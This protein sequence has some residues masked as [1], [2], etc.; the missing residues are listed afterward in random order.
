VILSGHVPRRHLPT[1]EAEIEQ[2]IAIIR[3]LFPA[4]RPEGSVGPATARSRGF[5][6]IVDSAVA[7]TGAQVDI[8]QARAGINR[9]AGVGG[10]AGTVSGSAAVAFLSGKFSHAPRLFPT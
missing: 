6:F 4:L 7:W 5:G 9:A 3:L 1:H 8:D 2:K 10:V